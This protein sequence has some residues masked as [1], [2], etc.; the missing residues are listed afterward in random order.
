MACG[1]LSN[2]L[3]NPA[4][5][6]RKADESSSAEHQFCGEDFF[7]SEGRIDCRLL[8]LNAEQRFQLL[9]TSKLVVGC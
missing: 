9:E 6:Q 1:H 2:L 7:I 8:T 5:Y 4:K 3:F